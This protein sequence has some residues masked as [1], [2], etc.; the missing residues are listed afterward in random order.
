V[1]YIDLM[2]Q[3]RD[4]SQP[5]V[6]ATV[7]RVEKPTSAKPGAKAIITAGGVLNGWIGGSCAEPSVK[8]EAAGV[9]RDGKPR[10]LRLCPP[11]KMGMAP[12]EGVTELKLTCMSGGTLEI[13]LEPHL[14]KPELL[15]I[16]HLPVAA[17]L[18][19]IG[20]ALDYSVTIIGEGVSKS[21]YPDAD[22]VLDDLDFSHLP[23]GSSTYVV[24]AS[25]GNYDE[26]ALEA[27]LKS[28][29]LYVSLVASRK[30]AASVRNYLRGSGLTDEQLKKLKYPA[31]L[32]IGAATPQEIALSVLA[33]IV[34]LRSKGLL[35][36]MDNETNETKEPETAL[37]PVCGMTVEV[38]SAHHVS[39]YNGEQY[40]FCSAGCKRSFDAD[41][42]KYVRENETKTSS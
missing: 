38:A 7:V 27:A 8:R 39:E 3:L 40:Y 32:D 20:K 21:H 2:K 22:H 16:G 10:L 34:E 35:M 18:V 28:K 9:L 24:V 42:V 41:P 1:E 15:V 30:R 19:E 26:P 5:F 23:V 31:G 33:E 37:D 36:A 29:A 17:S 13:Y 12:Q 4:K 25:H 14:P 11:E 6:E